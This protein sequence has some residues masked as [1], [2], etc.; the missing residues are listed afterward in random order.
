MKNTNSLKR[1]IPIVMLFVI[2]L[3]LI[4]VVGY[5]NFSNHKAT[6]IRQQQE[7]LLTIAKSISRSI[8]EF[9]NYKTNSLSVL[10]R[11][12]SII[13]L[14]KLNKAEED[15]S[16]HKKNLK[17]F[18]NKYKDE[19]DRIVLLNNEGRTIYEY[20]NQ[21][22]IKNNPID[23]SIVSKVLKNNEGFVSREYLSGSNKFSFDIVE[24]IFNNDKEIIGILLNTIDLNKLYKN[25]IYPIKPGEKGYAMVKN[26]KGFIVMHAVRDQIGIESIKVRKELFPEYD[27]TDLEELNRKQIEEGEGYHIY[28]S[29]WWQDESKG[30]TPKINSYTRLNVGDLSWIISVQMDYEE[31]EQPIKSTLINISVISMIIALILM[32]GLYIILKIDKKRKELEIEGIY[33]KELNKAWEELIKSEERLRH[34]QQLETIGTLSNSIS[35]EFNNLLSPILGYSEILLQGID[36][37]GTIY[38]DISEINKSALRLK[39]LTE[40]I[41]GFSRDDGKALTLECLEVNQVLKQSIK[42]IKSILP[43]KLEI[44]EDIKIKALILG[45]STQIQQVLLN[46]Y[47]NAYHAMESGKGILKVN[48]RD[49]YI[50][51]KESK[52]LN[53]PKGKYVKIQV[54]DNGSGMDE[55]RLDH[56]FD[57]YFT[58]KEVGKGTGLGLPVVR[59]IVKNHKGEIIVK[60]QID[61][62]TTIDIYLPTIEEID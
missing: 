28:N 43:Y 49:L 58:T 27:W 46:L 47:T 26:M 12:P 38:E 22:F 40:Q 50:S 39:E 60:S 10:A 51:D 15:S 59:D 37:N 6:V 18:F 4:I 8:N 24:P 31:I 35:H 16:I 2:L 34:S 29:R 13:E 33:L 11:D 41:L 14:L 48:L 5:K 7:H 53:L 3:T 57:Y 1:L 17:V 61:I 55:E 30:L 44:E 62:G 9:I 21:D 19:M 56:I 45:N 36:R 42:L 52:E 23:H 32:I 25:L 54:R 20:G